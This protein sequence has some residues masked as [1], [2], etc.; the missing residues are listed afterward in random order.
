MLQWHARVV[1]TGESQSRY[2]QPGQADKKIMS[3]VQPE[4]IRHCSSDNKSSSDHSLRDVFK[5]LLTTVGK[6]ASQSSLA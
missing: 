6:E 4:K 1:E 3:C 2:A 5:L